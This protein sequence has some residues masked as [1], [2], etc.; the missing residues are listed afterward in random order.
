MTK[1]IELAKKLKALAER[2]VGGEKE[3]AEAMLKSFMLKHGLRMEDI[4]GEKIDKYFFKI[5]KTEKAL[6]RLFQQIVARVNKDIN[7]YGNIPVKTINKYKLKG[8]F[9]IECTV[10]EYVEIEAM[11]SFYKVLYA[12][13]L[14][15]FYSAFV[16]AN[17]LGVRGNTTT[18]ELSPEELK[19]WKRANDMASTIKS[20]SFRKQLQDGV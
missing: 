5:E 6:S 17:D 2:G 7:V 20:K 4:D 18:A 3:N 15:V 8:N 16:Q 9:F 19:Q 10:A 12:A 13:E 1:Q 11:Y 14:K